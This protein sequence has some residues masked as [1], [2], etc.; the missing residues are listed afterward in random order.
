[1]PIAIW[2]IKWLILKSVYLTLLIY[3]RY[4]MI[5]LKKLKMH[6]LMKLDDGL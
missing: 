1:M 2:C 3:L 4:Y 5:R 6:K